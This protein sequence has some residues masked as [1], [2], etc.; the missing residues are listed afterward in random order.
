MLKITHINLMKSIMKDAAHKNVAFNK[1][2]SYIHLK[3]CAHLKI[4]SDW[5]L[6]LHFKLLLLIR[7]QISNIAATKVVQNTPILTKTQGSYK[8]SILVNF[9]RNKSRTENLCLAG[10]LNSVQPGNYNPIR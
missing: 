6:V 5:M 4:S 10:T 2:N 1:K 7:F 9:G 3:C 8:I